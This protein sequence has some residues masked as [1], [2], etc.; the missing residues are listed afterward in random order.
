MLTYY[1]V[2]LENLDGSILNIE[3]RLVYQPGK[4]IEIHLKPEG[5]LSQEVLRH[6][7]Q[8]GKEISLALENVAKPESE[9]SKLGERVRTKIQIE[10][11]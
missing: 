9:R 3:C 10:E 11:V 1:L 8:A 7:S 4:G 6:L 2:S 5:S